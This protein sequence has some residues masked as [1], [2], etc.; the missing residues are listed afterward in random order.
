MGDTERRAR[1]GLMPFIYGLACAQGK[2]Y[3]GRCDNAS[4]IDD[5]FK[6]EGSAWTKKYKPHRR[7]F[8]V[9]GDRFDEDKHVLRLMSKHGVDNV[10]GGTFSR[11]VLPDTDLEAIERM[12]RGASDRCFHCGEPGHF[13]NQCPRVVTSGTTPHNANTNAGKPWSH[14]EDDR[15]VDEI[16]R[17]LSIN[18]ICA[19][20][21]RTRNAITARIKR[22][23]CPSDERSLLSDESGDDDDCCWSCF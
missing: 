17:G 10:R 2:Y 13:V 11:V 19:A 18:E 6:G 9:K 5:H 4:R 7:L 23:H 8:T 14:E 3:V 21:G 15:L 16:D 12:L 20:H 1:T 22:V